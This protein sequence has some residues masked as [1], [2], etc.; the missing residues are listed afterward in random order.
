M[1]TRSRIKWKLPWCVYWMKMRVRSH[2]CMR[3]WLLI[4]SGNSELFC[5]EIISNQAKK[6]T[7]RHIPVHWSHEGLTLQFH[8]QENG[9]ESTSLWHRCEKVRCNCETSGSRQKLRGHVINNGRIC[10]M[11]ILRCW[12]HGA[13]REI[14]KRST[15]R[16]ERQQ[17]TEQE[18]RR[19]SFSVRYTAIYKFCQDTVGEDLEIGRLLHRE[20][21]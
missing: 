15:T 18:W 3:F 4:D 17:E 2:P 9:F 20:V 13:N 10:C 11:T 14:K 5:V 6:S 16:D 19:F 8:H 12:K 21:Q 7:N 1:N